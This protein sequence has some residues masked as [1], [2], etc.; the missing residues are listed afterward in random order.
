MACLSVSTS[1]QASHALEDVNVIGHQE[2]VFKDVGL[3]GSM[4]GHAGTGDQALVERLLELGVPMGAADAAGWA[5]L[6]WAAG[7]GHADCVARLLEAGAGVGARDAQ[8][9]LPLH[10]AAERGWA[11]VVALL[12]PAMLQAG[13]DLHVPV[14][15]C[16][17]LSARE[18]SKPLLFLL[19]PRGTRLGAPEK[20]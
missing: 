10:W 15:C 16:K 8:D 18:D 11:Q 7:S 4:H 3:Q 1:I 6:A 12:V 19:L 17:F 9:R 13:L 5:P 14:R 20:K 2:A